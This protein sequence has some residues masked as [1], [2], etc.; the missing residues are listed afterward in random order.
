MS[1]FTIRASGADKASLRHLVARFP[2]A[3]RPNPSRDEVA[4]APELKQEGDSW[5]MGQMEAEET[6]SGARGCALAAAAAAAAARHATGTDYP[7][8]PCSMPGQWVLEE[9]SGRPRFVG[10]PEGGLRDSGAGYFL[11]M[12][13]CGGRCRHC[14]MLDQAGAWAGPEQLNSADGKHT[15]E[16]HCSRCCSVVRPR[17][18][19]PPTSSKSAGQGQRVHRRPGHRH[20]HLQARAA[21]PPPDVRLGAREQRL[22][23]PSRL[24]R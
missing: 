6:K 20:V 3:F 4:N 8:L 19:A 23:A 5:L 15:M 13:V 24:H 18:H 22:P 21:A 17:W 12:K 16:P 7:S 2:L 14:P 10:Q 1:E 9:Q 11:L